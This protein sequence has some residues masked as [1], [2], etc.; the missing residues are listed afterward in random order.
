MMVVTLSSPPYDMSRWLFTP[1]MLKKSSN[2]QRCTL[3]LVTLRFYR[4]D[5]K[6]HPRC[7]TQWVLPFVVVHAVGFARR[8]SQPAVVVARSGF[9]PLWWCAQWQKT[10]VWCA[11]TRVSWRPTSH[12]A[13]SHFQWACAAPRPLNHTTKN[14]LPGPDQPHRAPPEWEGGGVGRDLLGI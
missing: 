9:R 6:R 1:S 5:S 11:G 10:L 2:S 13:A 12:L 3:V 7:C 4:F 14:Q 8:V